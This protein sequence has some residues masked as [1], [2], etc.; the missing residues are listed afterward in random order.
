[1]LELK[2]K[3]ENKDETEIP[4]III[5]QEVRPRHYRFERVAGEY[6]IDGFMLLILTLSMISGEEP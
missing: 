6:H 4:H 2:N 5:L 1:M 3:L